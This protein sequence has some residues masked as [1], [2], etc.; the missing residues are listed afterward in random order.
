ME[1]VNVLKMYLNEISSFPVLTKEETLALAKK[2][3]EGNNAARNKIINSNLRL[4]VHIAKPYAK[5]Y[6][7][8]LEDLISSGNIGIMTAISKFD[9]SH[10]ANF[11]TYASYWI[12][13]AINTNLRGS[14]D[15]RL[16][17][18]KAAVLSKKINTYAS[19]IDDENFNQ[20]SIPSE[21][22]N[23]V[24]E[25]VENRMLSQ[26]TQKMLSSM[27]SRSASILSLHYGINSQ[28]QTLEAIG[29][30]LNLTKERVRQIEREAIKEARKHSY[31]RYVQDYIA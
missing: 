30:K 7:V 31:I 2:A 11:C 12:K 21:Y 16:P 6:H 5:K 9:P 13:D 24:E 19:S 3:Q 20:G 4:V 27:D 29:T 1:D 17:K 23:N 26:Y 8:A 25:I 22:V 10:Y 14:H 15:I 28:P 18:D